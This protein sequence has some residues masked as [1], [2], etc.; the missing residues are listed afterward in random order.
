M[1]NVYNGVAS[2]DVAVLCVEPS[3]SP[4]KN[5]CYLSNKYNFLLNLSDFY[6]MCCNKHLFHNY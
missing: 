3:L 5:R 1:Y 2:G 4:T 6:K